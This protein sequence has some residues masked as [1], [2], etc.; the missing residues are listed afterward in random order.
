MSQLL[1][2]IVIDTREQRPIRFGQLR[3]TMKKLD[4]GDYALQGMEKRVAVERK[5][6]QDLWGTLSQP[7]N[8]ARFQRELARAQE[9]GC[10]LHVVVEGNAYQALRPSSR[11][12]L[13]PARLLDRL[14]ETCHRYGAAATFGGHRID[15]SLP[16]VVVAVLRGAWRAEGS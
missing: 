14:W 12:A 11:V 5:S 16:A 15:G 1:P 13:A 6:L 7:E 3:T 8:W 4:F 2:K 10:R 9:A